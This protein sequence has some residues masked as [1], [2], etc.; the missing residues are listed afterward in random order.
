[1]AINSKL[2]TPVD[3]AQRSYVSDVA[4]TFDSKISFTGTPEAAFTLD[5]VGGGSVTIVANVDNTGPGTVVT[6][7]FTGGS[8]NATSLAD[9]RRY[10]DHAASPADG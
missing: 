3:K 2:L 4:I 6:L 7:T 9:G 10:R 8:V 1:M 5:K